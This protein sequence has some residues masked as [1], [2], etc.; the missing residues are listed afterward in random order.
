MLIDKH[1][2]LLKRKA[3][4][5]YVS[6]V[7]L[8]YS[9]FGAGMMVLKDKL[10]GTEGCHIIASYAVFGE[11]TMLV[12]GGLFFALSMAL[13]WMLWDDA[14]RSIRLG[15]LNV[16]ASSLL[17]ALL[18]GAVGFEGYLVGFQ[19]F[20]A[21]AVCVY[22]VGVL[23]IVVVLFTAYTTAYRSR[24]LLPGVALWATMVMAPG[25]VAMKAEAT[26]LDR[27]AIERIQKGLSDQEYYL[28]YSK[29]CTNCE[30][31]IKYCKTEYQGDINLALCP[32]D[33][34]ASAL[35]ALKIDS[36]PALIVNGK[37]KKEILVGKTAIMEH[38]QAKAFPIKKSSSPFGGS[39][40]PFDSCPATESCS[41]S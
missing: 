12:T 10:C 21:H 39:S 15:R 11:M 20:A 13:C 16:R 31:V 3:L 28:I 24:L 40:V 38:L 8:L 34:S 18:L 37:T 41:G 7:G 23:A 9:A 33:K 30:E 36:V 35:K 2:N 29:S 22:C 14:E 4:P 32:A 25:M 5:I 6:A 1:L 19:L 27:V 26:D 17:E